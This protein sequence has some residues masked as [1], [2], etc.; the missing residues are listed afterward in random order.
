MAQRKSCKGDLA[1]CHPKRRNAQSRILD[2]NHDPEC[3]RSGTRWPRPCTLA[4][5]I[6]DFLALWRRLSRH[7]LCTSRAE[8]RLQRSFESQTLFNPNITDHEC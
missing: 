1:G 6:M 7:G 2:V 4:T 5:T 3:R 8:M